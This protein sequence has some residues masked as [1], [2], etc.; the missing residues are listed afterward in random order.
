MPPIALDVFYYDQR[1]SFE[2][3]DIERKMDAAEMNAWVKP[4]VF[5]RALVALQLEAVPG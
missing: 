5:D 1:I 4:L 2:G 3:Y